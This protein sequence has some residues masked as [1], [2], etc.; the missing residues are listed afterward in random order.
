MWK[1]RTGTGLWAALGLTVVLLPALAF[2]DGPPDPAPPAPAS[3]PSV[4]PAP[5][6][7]PSAQAP[8]PQGQNGRRH[9]RHKGADALQNRP[10]PL[11]ERLRDRLRNRQR[12]DQ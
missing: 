8:E 11:V 10:M 9:P 2:G 12:G 6:A 5:P 1:Q 7:A 4:L 3:A